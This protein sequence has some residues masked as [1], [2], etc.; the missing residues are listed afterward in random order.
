LQAA[1]RTIS[2]PE[3]FDRYEMF[4]SQQWLRVYMRSQ[5]VKHNKD[6]LES[7]GD[8]DGRGPSRVPGCVDLGESDLDR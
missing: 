5:M 2:M 4:M 1:N 7:V 3:V 6:L 8:T